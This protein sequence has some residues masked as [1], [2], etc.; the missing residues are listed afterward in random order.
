MRHMLLSRTTCNT[1]MCI[2]TCCWRLKHDRT[3]LVTFNTSNTRQNAVLEHIWDM[4]HCLRE[5]KAR[6]WK[7]ALATLIHIGGFPRSRRKAIPFLRKY[8]SDPGSRQRVPWAQGS[9]RYCVGSLPVCLHRWDLPFPQSMGAMPC[10]PHPIG[11]VSHLPGTIFTRIPRSIAMPVGVLPFDGNGIISQRWKI[12]A[13]RLSRADPSRSGE[14]GAP[15]GDIRGALSDSQGCRWRQ[16]EDRLK[17][18]RPWANAR[19]CRCPCGTN[20]DIYL[21]SSA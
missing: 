14:T 13:L 19:L 5:M 3:Q 2:H 7:L 1:Y 9:W 17:N 4:V 18:G 6:L 12:N 11:E 20:N 8:P 16:R 10:Y 15:A 21:L